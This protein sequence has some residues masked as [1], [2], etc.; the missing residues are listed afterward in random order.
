MGVWETY[1]NPR[2]HETPFP[3]CGTSAID[4]DTYLQA[5]SALKS[6]KNHGA[7]RRGAHVN[8]FAGLLT[9]A[10]DGGSLTYK[11]LK[12][13]SSSIIPVGAKQGRG[14]K[15][16]SFPAMPFERALLSGLREVPASELTGD[17]T[18]T[19]KVESLGTEKGRLE[20]L[21]K[22]WEAQMDNVATV[23]MVAA[24]LA[25]YSA[26][27]AVVSADLTEA[28]R[29]AASPVSESWGEFRS[30]AGVLEKDN[31]DEMRTRVK[32]A[33]RRCVS[34]V[35]CA[36]GHKGRVSVANVRVEFS[37]SKAR[38]YVIIYKPGKSNHRIKRE[39]TLFV[40]SIAMAST[41]A[42]T[43]DFDELKRRYKEHFAI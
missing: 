10:N 37:T 42:A 23:A 6:R 19:K 20:S 2:F 9:D 43:I 18:A 26:E 33:L 3:S 5:Q 7:G 4:K 40:D 24:K 41:Q 1:T 14:T 15:W 30:L 31:S 22:A 13:R 11:H 8:L 16:T 38:E 36:F 29:E 28:Q 21:V 32:A 17:T 12:G 35:R 27:L 39:G 34:R 25:Q